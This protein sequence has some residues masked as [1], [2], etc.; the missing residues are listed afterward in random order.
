M[1]SLIKNVIKTKTK[2]K[3]NYSLYIPEDVHEMYDYGIKSLKRY[4]K[5]DELN[6]ED[7]FNDA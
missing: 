2:D 4:Q 7:M 3:R 5:R 6:F 1:N